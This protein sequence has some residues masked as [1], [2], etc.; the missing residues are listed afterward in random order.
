MTTSA[1]S[2]ALVKQVPGS[3]ATRTGR[4]IQAELMCCAGIQ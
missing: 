1:S 4:H 2:L 3:E